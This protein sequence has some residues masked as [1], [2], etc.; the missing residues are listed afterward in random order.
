MKTSDLLQHDRTSSTVSEDEHG[1]HLSGYLFKQSDHFKQWNVRFFV[2][3][4][5][6]HI[7]YYK[8]E[9]DTSPKGFFSV[10]G[11]TFTIISGTLS[12]FSSFFFLPPSIHIYLDRHSVD[13]Q[14]NCANLFFFP[15][16]KNIDTTKVKSK[17]LYIFEVSHPLSKNVLRLG[18]H[19]KEVTEMWVQ[20]LRRVSTNN[21]TEGTSPNEKEDRE[22]ANRLAR[23]MNS[24]ST[25]DELNVDD[26]NNNDNEDTETFVNNNNDTNVNESENENNGNGMEGDHHTTQ[27]QNIKEVHHDRSNSEKSNASN[28]ITR[29]GTPPLPSTTFTT[30]ATKNSTPTPSPTAAAA[31]ATAAT[32]TTFQKVASKKIKKKN[33]N[34]SPRRSKRTK[35]TLEDVMPTTNPLFTHVGMSTKL[36]IAVVLF[37]IFGQ[38][39]G[40]SMLPWYIGSGEDAMERTLDVL[41][42][43]GFLLGVLISIVLWLLC[44]EK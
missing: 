2:A 26:D 28:T 16:S 17:P 34:V 15:F 38:F 22:T 44:R 10:S 27:N 29:T 20:T 43:L 37:P 14:I 41:G 18:S 40:R 35:S 13:Q 8:Q 6:D 30:T 5:T 33:Q 31:A 21:T 7:K 12:L 23:A 4:G 32:S 3:T 36:A 19:T 24:I 1:N 11:C 9:T 25:F 42:N 39:F